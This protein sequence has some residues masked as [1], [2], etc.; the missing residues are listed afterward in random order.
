M[1]K[2]WFGLYA[3]ELGGNREL[4]PASPAML[5]RPH[6]VSEW[7]VAR[8]LCLLMGWRW[9]PPIPKLP[10]GRRISEGGDGRGLYA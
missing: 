3:R 9:M 4:P 8:R 10:R 2:Q 6:D 1:P 5:A 7:A